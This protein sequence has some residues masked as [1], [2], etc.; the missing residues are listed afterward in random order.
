MAKL[1]NIKVKLIEKLIQIQDFELLQ[2]FYEFINHSSEEIELD[3]TQNKIILKSEQ[4]IL[5][6]KVY[7]QEDLEKMD[8]E[9][10]NSK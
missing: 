1:E 9:C 5:E 4:D 3:A 6:G 7:S 8:E 10:L 2:A